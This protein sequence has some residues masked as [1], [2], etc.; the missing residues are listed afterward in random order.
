MVHTVESEN[1][2]ALWCLRTW[3]LEVT[4]PEQPANDLLSRRED[5]LEDREILAGLRRELD[6][7]PKIHP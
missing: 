1:K 6:S 7:P 4:R 5:Q 2:V 3:E